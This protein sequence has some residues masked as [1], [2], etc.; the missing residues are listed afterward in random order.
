MH[1]DK[2]RTY[3][4]NDYSF[5]NFIHLD[6]EQVKQVLEWRNNPQIRQYMYNKEEIP[7]EGHLTFVKGLVN[8]IDVAYW[9]VYRKNEPIGVVNLIDIDEELERAELGYYMIPSRMSSGLGVEFVYHLLLFSFN[10]IHVKQLIGAIDTKNKNALLVDEYMGFVLGE[11]KSL[12]EESDAR[13]IEWTLE[14]DDFL[15]TAN[16]KNDIRNFVRFVRTHKV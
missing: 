13:Y 2:N 7:L 9:L 15:K 5:R 16:G 6:N 1:I 4:V 14:K 11:T 12:S 10:E 8:R 3:E